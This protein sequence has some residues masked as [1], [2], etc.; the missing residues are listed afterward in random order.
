[1][2]ELFYD[3]VKLFKWICSISGLTYEEMPLLT[4]LN[5]PQRGEIFVE[6]RGNRMNKL[7]QGGINP[8][9]GKSH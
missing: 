5:Y 3:I 6:K 7:Q 1:M 4:A 9:I 8:N 2:N